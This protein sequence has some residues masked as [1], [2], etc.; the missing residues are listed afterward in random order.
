MYRAFAFVFF[1][2]CE[3]ETTTAE[4]RTGNLSPYIENDPVPSPFKKSPPDIPIS[5]AISKFPM[6]RVGERNACLDT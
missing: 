2:F 3:N 4:E 6:E 1:F 5:L